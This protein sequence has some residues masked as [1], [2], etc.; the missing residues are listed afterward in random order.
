MIAMPR[1]SMYSIFTY[2]WAICWVNVGKYSIDGAFGMV[3][4]QGLDDFVCKSFSSWMTLLKMSEKI[5]ADCQ[6]G[7][8]PH[9]MLFDLLLEFRCCLIVATG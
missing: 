5:V 1:C 2:I 6:N 8:A 4:Q 9:L 7:Q 3:Y